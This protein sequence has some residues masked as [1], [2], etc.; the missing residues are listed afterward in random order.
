MLPGATVEQ[1][2]A[3]GFHRN[4][5]LNQ[6]GGIDVEEARFE[7]L[8]DRVNT[9]G[10]VWLGTTLACAQCHN[11]K[12][13]PVSQKDYYRMLAFYD[14]AEYSVYGAGRG[15]RGPLDR[16]ARSRAVDARAGEAARGA[17]TGGGRAAAGDRRPRPRGRPRRLRAGD[18][19]PRAGVHSAHPGALRGEE[20]GRAPEARRRLAARLGRGE[21]QGHLHRHRPDG[22]RG[23]HGVPT[24]GPPRPVPAPAGAGPRRLGRVRG[25]R[26]R[27]PRGVAGDTARPGGRRREREAPI[28]RAPSR[29]PRRRPAGA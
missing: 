28:G 19:G 21:G 16:R 27:G 5:Q 14:N 17:A 22:L 12:F 15:D 3:T 6:E 13:D 11:H 20:R 29:R 8:V 23:G 25:D 7:T 26:A 4:T 10:T 1:K 2:T 24:G 9:T 18:R